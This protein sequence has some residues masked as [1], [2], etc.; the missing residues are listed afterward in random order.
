[1]SGLDDDMQVRGDV[2]KHM[3]YA[4]K[5]GS[6]SVSATEGD[7]KGTITSDTVICRYDHFIG[8]DSRLDVA[9]RKP[10]R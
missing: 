3:F 9:V 7:A 2:Y 10:T 6:T 5:N 1:M 4:A 8:I